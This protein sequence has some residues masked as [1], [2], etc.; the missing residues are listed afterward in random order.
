MNT[1]FSNTR[2]IRSLAATLL[3][4]LAALAALGGCQ[5]PPGAI[6]PAAEVSTPAAAMPAPQEP[7]DTTPITPVESAGASAA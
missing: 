7:F 5:S 4:S 2:N 6:A 1:A 3:L